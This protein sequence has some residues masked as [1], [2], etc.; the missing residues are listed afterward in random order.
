[1]VSKEKYNTVLRWNFVI[2]KA[3]LSAR[4][5]HPMQGLPDSKTK[6]DWHIMS[7][8]GI[9]I[10]SVVS[11]LNSYRGDAR[12]HSALSTICL[13]L[14]LGDTL[15]NCSIIIPPFRFLLI[16]ERIS[17]ALPVWKYI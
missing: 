17:I 9:G 2:L 11:T 16:P 6:P 7:C 12:E 13:R 5:V 3:I 10:V 1:V 8:K 14:L 15:E 4:E